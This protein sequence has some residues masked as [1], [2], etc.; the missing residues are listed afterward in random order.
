M[1]TANYLFFCLVFAAVIFG[2]DFSRDEVK[3]NPARFRQVVWDDTFTV[4]KSGK[5]SIVFPMNIS[6]YRMP[7]CELVDAKTGKSPETWEWLTVQKEGMSYKAK[8]RE[9][10]HIHCVGLEL[11]PWRVKQ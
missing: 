4:P 3:K 11:K 9:R 2:Q 8:P 7:A 1:R 10:I 6:T 5:G